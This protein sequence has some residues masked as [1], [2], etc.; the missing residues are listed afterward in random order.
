MAQ[1]PIYNENAVLIKP[2]DA[3]YVLTEG[4]LVP[5]EARLSVYHS[6]TRSQNLVAQNPV[7]YIPSPVYLLCH[8]YFRQLYQIKTSRI[9]L[10]AQSPLAYRPPQPLPQK[11]VSMSRSS[12][13]DK[14]LGAMGSHECKCEQYE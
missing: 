6:W 4:A 11:E 12:T 14:L 1:Q 10:L 3:P 5:V 7:T 8:K 2:W 13:F 9:K